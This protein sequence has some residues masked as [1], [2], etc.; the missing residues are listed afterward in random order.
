MSETAQEVILK[1]IDE[2]VKKLTDVVDRLALAEERRLERDKYQEKQNE[3]QE[4]FNKMVKEWMEDVKP[5]ITK[6]AEWQAIRMK[7]IS[8]I[9]VAA[10]LGILSIFYAF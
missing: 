3:R 10:T 7:V 9:I 4:E 2:S 1:S 8:S 6:A 5:I